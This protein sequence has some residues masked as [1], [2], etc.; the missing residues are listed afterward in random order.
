MEIRELRYFLAVAREG[1]ITIAAESLNISQPGL[2]KVIMNI[3][4]EL[5]KKLFIREN[6]KITLT[7]DGMLLRKRAGEII[8]LVDK[9]ESEFSKNNEDQISGNI[10]IGGGETESMRLIAKAI[11]NLQSKHPHI[12]Y[13]FF[14]GNADDVTEKIDKGLLDFGILIEPVDIKKY[15]Y[16]RLPTYDT[17]GV[18][19][20]KDSELAKLDSVTFND[21]Q[22]Y[23]LIS[24]RQ[25]ITKDDISSW[26]GYDLNNLNIIGTYNL[27]YNASLMVE[28]GI[29]YAL[30]LDKLVNTTGN[31]NLCFKPLKPALTSNLVLVW[32]KYQIFSKATEKFLVELQKEL[33]TD[34]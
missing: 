29:G 19:M 7:E 33:S 22:D 32:K 15:D 12:H 21:L 6:R 31:S 4:D 26:I 24:S 2:S 5:G 1:S 23:P 17:W 10:Y 25:T 16:L 30:C 18:L 34:K 28:E 3:E 14:S 11:K 9:T 20:R 13:N 8:D 27:I